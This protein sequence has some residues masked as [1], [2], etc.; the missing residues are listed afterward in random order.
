[1]D[2]GIP[3]RYSPLGTQ[4]GAFPRF[5]ERRR[6]E[7]KKAE[8]TIQAASR[9][10]FLGSW[11][12]VRR[13]PVC[14]RSRTGRYGVHIK[15]VIGRQDL[16]VR[17]RPIGAYIPVGIIDMGLGVQGCD[18]AIRGGGL[19]VRCTQTGLGVRSH[20]PRCLRTCPPLE[21]L[22]YDVFGLNES[23]D[24]HRP[25]ASFDRLRTGLGQVRGSTFPD[26]VRDRLLSSG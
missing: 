6:F 25:M 8:V 3:G 18:L 13:V 22:F 12:E 14:V 21:D 2:G 15:P 5:T 9:F 17:L 4:V 16:R 19:P 7:R 23:D 10:L 11:Q 1:V 26:Q 20:R 24:G